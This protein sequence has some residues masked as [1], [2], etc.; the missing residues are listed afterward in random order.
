MELV[1]QVTK[2]LTTTNTTLSN[3]VGKSFETIGKLTDTFV[4]EKQENQEKLKETKNAINNPVTLRGCLGVSDE[5]CRQLELNPNDKEVQEKLLR[6][7]MRED[8]KF[9][10]RKKALTEHCPALVVMHALTEQG[11]QYVYAKHNRGRQIALDERVQSFADEEFRDFKAGLPRRAYKK[12][13]ASAVSNSA[14][15]DEKEP[16]RARVSKCSICHIPGHN[17]KAC[18]T[19]DN[20]VDCVVVVCFCQTALV[21]MSHLQIRT[22]A[23]QAAT[24][25]VTSSSCH[26]SNI[27]RTA[28]ATVTIATTT[29]SSSSH[30][31]N[32]APNSNVNRFVAVLALD[33]WKCSLRF[34]RTTS[35]VLGA[36]IGDLHCTFGHS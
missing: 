14:E 30:N 13:R 19:K 4:A 25:T 34:A 9:T 6:A 31:S 18:P 23:L 27:A 10:E 17:K 29:S 2:E 3:C 22:A 21:R 36:E 1:Q 20:K 16:K 28:T 15:S 8:N 7:L 12:R 35:A 24:A 11:V 32:I 33:L 5:L 26:H